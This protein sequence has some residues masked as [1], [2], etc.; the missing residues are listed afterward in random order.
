[1][2]YRPGRTNIADALSRLNS[3]DQK[4]HS[5]EETD[6]VRVIAQECT[7]VAMSAREVEREP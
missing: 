6:F 7:P 3:M 2:V 1:M 4:D 5:S